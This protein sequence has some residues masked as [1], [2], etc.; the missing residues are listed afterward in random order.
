MKLKGLVVI[1]AVFFFDLL[2]FK[3]NVIWFII[4]I[5]TL[6]LFIILYYELND[7]TEKILNLLLKNIDVISLMFLVVILPLF[8]LA[9]SHFI[10]LNNTINIWINSSFG[11]RDEFW[12]AILTTCAILIS[13]FPFIIDQQQRRKDEL[14]K[15]ETYINIILTQLARVSTNS[16]AYKDSFLT[17]LKESSDFNSF[18]SYSKLLFNETDVGKIKK[19]I[20]RELLQDSK[21]NKKIRDYLNSKPSIDLGWPPGFMIKIIDNSLL[22]SLNYKLNKENKVTD[23]LLISLSKLN[24]KI[25]YINSSHQLLY[26]LK[27]N[28]S[29]IY[30]DLQRT[31]N[32]PNY[33]IDLKYF[34]LSILDLDKLI[35]D[36]FLA[37]ED[38]NITSFYDSK[39]NIEKNEIAKYEKDGADGFNPDNIEFSHLRIIV[40]RNYE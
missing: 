39:I 34:Y 40:E 37:L 26:T 15:Q 2:L 29:K 9:V 12:E 10:G 30:D 5:S 33:E 6:I 1:F 35:K 20:Q 19:I 14:N 7:L 28:S 27:L 24:E 3:L 18:N 22:L 38:F 11:F 21:I 36:V 8:L 25:E 16:E 13:F 31:M 17:K 23:K 32:N 4:P